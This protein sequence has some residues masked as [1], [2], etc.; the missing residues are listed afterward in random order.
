MLFLWSSED[1]HY[2][3]LEKNDAFCLPVYSSIHLSVLRS[4]CLKSCPVRNGIILKSNIPINNILETLSP[5]PFLPDMETVVKKNGETLGV[6][7]EM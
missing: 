4:D 3:L 5:T 2:A 1:T 7:V 6:N